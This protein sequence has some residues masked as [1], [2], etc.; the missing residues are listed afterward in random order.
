MNT[1]TELRARIAEAEQA[2]DVE[3]DHARTAARRGDRDQAL[4][5]DTAAD[6]IGEHLDMFEDQLADLVKAQR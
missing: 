1:A 5:H 4:R 3:R 2:Y 6:L